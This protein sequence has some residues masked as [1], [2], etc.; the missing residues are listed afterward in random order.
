MNC[1]DSLHL[2]GIKNVLGDLQVSPVMHMASQETAGQLSSATS[3]FDVTWLCMPVQ[4]QI[5]Y[6][7]VCWDQQNI[8]PIAADCNSAIIAVYIHL[9]VPDTTSRSGQGV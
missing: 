4:R 3:I 1:T 2:S 6:S 8:M 5:Q 9:H 7:T